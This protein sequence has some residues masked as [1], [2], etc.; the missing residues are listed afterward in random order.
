ML[1]FYDAFPSY[2]QKGLHLIGESYAGL[3]LPFLPAEILRHPADV[4]AK[5]L[6]GLAVG[7]GCPGTSG[8]TPAKRG[9]CNGPYGSCDSRT[10]TPWQPRQPRQRHVRVPRR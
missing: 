5:Q 6:R 2:K 10:Q 7:N 3:L 9:S 1:A 8:A 4:P